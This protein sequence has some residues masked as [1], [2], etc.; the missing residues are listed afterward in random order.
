MSAERHR[1]PIV[2]LETGTLISGIGNGVA[3]V[4][5]PWLVLERTGSAAIAGLVSA[6]ALLPLLVSSVVAGAV[7]DA[8]GRR[9]TSVGSD[10]LSGIAA[11]AIPVV[12]IVGDLTAAWIVGL[13]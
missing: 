2:L 9:R 13:A 6:A 5:L 10:L 4:V 11:A 3:L 7:V 12:D 8:V 1:G